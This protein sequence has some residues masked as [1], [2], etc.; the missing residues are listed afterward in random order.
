MIYTFFNLILILLI[1]IFAGIEGS[2]TGLGGGAIISPILTIFLDYPLYLTIGVSL[3]STISTSLSSSL[4]YI[5]K[6]IANDNIAISLLTATTFGAIFGFLLNNYLYTHNLFFIVYIIF[7]VVLL[8]SSIFLIIKNLRKRYYPSKPDDSTYFFNL[9]GKYEE[10]GEII[11]YDGVR[12]VYGWIVMLFAGFLSGLL[13]IG[14]GILK[15]LGMDLIM[16]LPIKVSTTTSNFMIGITA[17]TSSI[18]YFKAGYIDFILLPFLTLGV[19]IG[20]WIGTRLLMKL[21]DNTVR[22]IFIIF[23][24]YLGAKLLLAGLNIDNILYSL[25]ITFIISLISFIL[26]KKVKFKE[27]EEEKLN[28]E[29]YIKED[30]AFINKMYKFQKIALIL[31]FILNISA[32]IYYLLTENILLSYIYYFILISIPFIEIL[33]ELKKYLN[34]K[35]TLYIALSTIIIINLILGMFILPF[36]IL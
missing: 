20:A 25:L 27:K 15:V 33:M 14:S 18:L 10:K 1:G 32:I 12:W 5:K 28:F 22:F 19:L 36:I 29:K 9:F 3:L 30:D 6:K 4:T 21:K 16:N 8:L 34:E 2:I 11:Y 17:D 31:L 7:G 13:G 23:V 26:L 35:N 24:S